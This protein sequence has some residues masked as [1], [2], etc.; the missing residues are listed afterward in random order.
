M[1]YYTLLL[2]CLFVSCNS[3]NENYEKILKSLEKNYVVSNM[4]KKEILLCWNIDSLK[5]IKD[6]IEY[7]KTVEVFYKQ[8]KSFVEYL[9]E[10]KGD[11]NKYNNW[12]TTKPLCS[13]NMTEKDFV[14]NS[15]AS[16][17]LIDNLLVGNQTDIIVND[18]IEKISRDS[19]K[20]IILD[21]RNENIKDLKREYVKYLNSIKKI[22]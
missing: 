12:V 5:F 7:K 9:I 1:K 4:P 17:V 6:S 20:E 21:N 8:K 3:N 15:K 18:Y 2:V 13:S 10:N 11:G 19:L 16:I 14:S 22:K